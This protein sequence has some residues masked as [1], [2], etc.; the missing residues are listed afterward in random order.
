MSQT[1]DPK[2]VFLQQ[3]KERF[4]K[5]LSYLTLFLYVVFV[6]ASAFVADYL[7]VMIIEYVL[8]QDA[9]KYPII[10]TAFDW[11]KIGSAFL[12]LIAAGVHAFFSALSQVKFELET[13]NETT[14]KVNPSKGE[15]HESKK[16]RTKR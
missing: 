9:S 4:Y 12:A 5:G 1:N 15:E 13:I 10:S 14:L 16:F 11:F 8:S 2:L 7:L 6:S 3:S